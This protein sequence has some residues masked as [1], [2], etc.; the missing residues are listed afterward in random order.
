MKIEKRGKK[1][2]L[3][4]KPG[5]GG[6]ALCI[7]LCVLISVFSLSGCNVEWPDE[8]RKPETS[9][10]ESVSSQQAPEQSEQE[11]QPEQSSSEESYKSENAS[12]LESSASSQI[13]SQPSSQASGT[14]SR[15][16][17]SSDKER[18]QTD[19]APE[20]KPASVEPEEQPVD[21]KKQYTV[22]FSIVCNTILDNMDQFN[23]DKI[24]MLPRDG[25]IYSARKVEFYEGESVF[26]VLLRESKKN[27]IHMEFRPTPM[28]N[29]NYILGIHNLY[30]FDC[31]ETSGW[32][33]RVNGW[34]PNY[35]CNRYSLKDGDVV[36]WVY[37]CNLG[38]D[39]GCNWMEDG[40]QGGK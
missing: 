35:G 21:N 20:G 3:R 8:V 36:E 16:P 24:D 18:Y 25:V 39:I 15:A 9:A 10:V 7:L 33:Y 40:Q 5:R 31:G 29:S 12:G 32:M 2:T 14:N 30:E 11:S 26:D 22:T 27:G 23:M 6:K 1:M 13:S 19:P 38:K 37:T 34:F 28:Y 17:V 4:I